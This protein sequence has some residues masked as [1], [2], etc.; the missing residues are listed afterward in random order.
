MKPYAENRKA[1][2]EY[3]ILEKFEGG[4]VLLGQEVKSIRN[5]GAKLQG[6]YV[7]LNRGE[8]WLMG[9]HVSPYAKAS[10]LVSYDP[11][12]DRKVL[13]TKREMNSLFGK[14]QQKGLTLVALSLYPRGRHI[15]LSFGLARGRKAHD[16]REKIKQRDLDREIRRMER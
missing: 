8:L 12:R 1:L 5:G 10:R 2:H 11:L 15:K 3:E 13:I 4:L 16:K 7:K 9:A 14:D 6:A